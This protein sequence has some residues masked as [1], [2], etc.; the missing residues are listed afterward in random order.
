MPYPVTDHC[1]GTRFFNPH[2]RG[3]K[4]LADLLRWMLFERAEPWPASLPLSPVAP[5]PAV[6]PADAMTITFVNH[7]TFLLQW[8]GVRVLTDPIFSQ[9]ASPFG[10]M[11]PR[12]VMP[13]GLA[14]EALPR[15]DV[16]LVSHNHYDHLDA[17]SVRWIVERD[18]PVI[19]T[20]LGNARVLAPLGGAVVVERDWWESWEDGPLRVQ[21]VPAQHWSNRLGVARNTALWGGFWLEAY[22]KSVYFAADSGYGPH[23]A[24]IGRRC[25][26]P[27][28][29][30]LPIGAYE[31]RWF[32]REQHM[33]PVEAVK[34]HQDLDSPL[35]V[36]SHF[37]TFRLTNEAHDAPV[38]ALREALDAQPSM[39]GQFR[40]LAQGETISVAGP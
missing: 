29:S 40:V 28:A 10:W 36:A 11:G 14:L 4:T 34:A 31:P 21:I 35:S 2:A 16:L 38:R 23:F 24:E 9:R 6:V 30:L 15:I 13:P 33:N 25:G 37:G 19:V 32:M 27:D 39:T 20:P 17:A 1:D 5:P 26:R 12:R 22:G 8:A 3:D 7:C 18:R